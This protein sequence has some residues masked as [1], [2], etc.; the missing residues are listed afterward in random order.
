VVEC[1]GLEMFAAGLDK[2]SQATFR[3]DKC[4]QV[5]DVEARRCLFGEKIGEK[6]AIS[7][8]LSID[9]QNQPNSCPKCAYG[10]K[11]PQG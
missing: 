2:F 4:L 5:F 7:R 6:A 10:S 3:G 9:G 11:K 8:M 1:G